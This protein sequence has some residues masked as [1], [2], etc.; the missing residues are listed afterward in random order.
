MATPSSTPGMDCSFDYPCDDG[1]NLYG[2]ESLVGRSAAMISL[3]GE[4]LLLPDNVMGDDDFA[5]EVSSMNSSVYRPNMR[6]VTAVPGKDDSDSGGD[7]DSPSSKETKKTSAVSEQNSFESSR[8]PLWI[9]R[10]PLWLKVIFLTSVTLLI[11]A[12]VLIGVGLSLALSDDDED[13]NLAD[14][15]RI[16]ENTY[17][18]G[19]PSAP[20]PAPDVPTVSPVSTVIEGTASP[21]Q[22]SISPTGAPVLSPTMRPSVNPS[23]SSVPTEPIDEEV[24]QFYVMAGRMQGDVLELAPEGLAK[25]PKRQGLSFLVQLGDWNSPQTEGCTESAYEEVSNLYQQS[26]IPVY[27]VV[28]DNEYN[29]TLASCCDALFMLRQLSYIRSFLLFDRLRQSQ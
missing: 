12:V 11:G 9:R 19:L 7:K 28:G 15:N 14:A 8:I 22:P 26:A 13:T 25:L 1:G 27:F 4:S 18:P 10:S 20:T 5:D 17:P 6:A 24:I 21:V 29:G 3:D 23:V 2:L 16:G